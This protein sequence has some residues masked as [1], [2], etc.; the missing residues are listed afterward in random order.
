MDILTFISSILGSFSWPI[1]IVMLAILFRKSLSKI[2][3]SI[4]LKKIK[5]GDL[6]VDFDQELNQLKGKVETIPSLSETPKQ[7]LSKRLDNDPQQFMLPLD[8]QMELI[9]Q[10]NPAAGIALAWSNVEREIQATIMRLALSPD[11]PGYNSSM[12]NIQL[13]RDNNII[14]SSFAESLEMMRQLRNRAVHEL[15]DSG[16]SI[17]EA[18]TYNFLAKKAI[19][20]LFFIKRKKQ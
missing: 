18:E 20:R 15:S 12:R 13:L 3:E 1:T 9:S 6:E 2:L 19:E 7:E 4:R 11:Y 5:R 17:N 10:I 16:L 14:N 8:N